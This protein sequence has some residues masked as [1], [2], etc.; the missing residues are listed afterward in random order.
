MYTCPCPSLIRVITMSPL[1]TSYTAP[2]ELKSTLESSHG[3]D[4]PSL[5]LLDPPSDTE[6]LPLPLK[7]RVTRVTVMKMMW[8]CWYWYWKHVVW[9]RPWVKSR[10]MWNIK[11]IMMIFWGKPV[12]EYICGYAYSRDIL[13]GVTWHTGCFTRGR[14]DVDFSTRIVLMMMMIFWIMT[15]KKKKKQ[16]T[17]S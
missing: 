10:F 13:Q 5:G 11:T 1:F 8:L 15:P 2:I 9:L 4:C 6:K 12:L 17:A 14:L 7:E 3:K 16:L